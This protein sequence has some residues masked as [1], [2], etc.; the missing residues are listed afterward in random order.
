MKKA[1]LILFIIVM[2]MLIIILIPRTRQTMLA[3]GKKIKE[4]FEKEGTVVLQ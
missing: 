4:S 3:W 1:A 2:I